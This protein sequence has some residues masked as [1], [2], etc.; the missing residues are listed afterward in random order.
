MNQHLCLLC[1]GSNTNGSAHLSTAREALSMAFPKIHFGETMQTEPIRMSNPTLF[2]NQLGWFTTLQS[3]EEIISF[4]KNI[5]K[6]C[7]RKPEDKGLGIVKLDLDLLIYDN[8]V[9]KP[10]DLQRSYV[11]EGLK[12]LSPHFCLYT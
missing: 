10:E 6:K 5:E 7:G 3:A 1:M 11:K 4:F 2:D 8:T 12:Q 9:L